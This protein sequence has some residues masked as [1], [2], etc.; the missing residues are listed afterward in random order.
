[1]PAAT[2]T[3]DDLEL[4]P[5]RQAA[6]SRRA[7]WGR[8]AFTTGL[9]VLVVLA[10]LGF[11]GVRNGTVRAA[12][13]DFE[14]EVTYAR[15]SRPGL[16]TVWSARVVATGSEPLPSELTLLTT[17]DYLDQ[18]DEN[19]FSPEPTETAQNDDVRSW[20][21][22]PPPGAREL[23]VSFDARLEPGWRIGVEARTTL[24]VDD[25]PVVDVSYRTLIVP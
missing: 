19:G 2:S 1:V 5:E 15:I 12:G 21:F 20:T 9:S 13:D 16:A 8:I 22:E 7:R 23:V 14:L 4:D 6:R 24:I 11:F 25:E 10:L 18:F 3:T 17:R